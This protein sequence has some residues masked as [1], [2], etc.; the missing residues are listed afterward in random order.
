MPGHVDAP[1]NLGVNLG[2]AAPLRIGLP[3][4]ELRNHNEQNGE[5]GEPCGNEDGMTGK[6]A[7]NGAQALLGKGEGEAIEGHDAAAEKPRERTLTH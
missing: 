2:N 6:G 7:R 4:Q 5:N 1:N 3:Q